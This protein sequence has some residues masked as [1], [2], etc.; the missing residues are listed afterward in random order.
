MHLTR[1]T[2][3]IILLVI[4]WTVSTLPLPW[5]VNNP[6]VSESAFYTILGIIAIVSIPFV[7]LGVVWH[8]KPELTT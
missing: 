8:L 1:K 7:M 4:I 5:I 6:V 3:T 2:K